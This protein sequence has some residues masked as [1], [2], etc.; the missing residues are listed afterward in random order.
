MSRRPGIAV[1]LA[2]GRGQRLRPA[3]DYTPKP[4]LPVDGCPT[5]DY[6]LTA[7]R[8]AGISTACIVTHHLAEQI[9]AYV[10]DGS[11]WSLRAVFCR[12]PE[13]NGTASALQT[14]AGAFPALFAGE[15]PFLLAA[16]DYA[17]A[18][19]ALDDLVTAH[20]QSEA[21]MTVSL[22]RLPSAE[23]IG[24]STVALN[25]D[26]RLLR[27]IEKPAPQDITT[28]LVASL[29]FV[30]PGET[31]AYLTGMERS[32]RG[33]YELQDVINR[34]LADGYTAD[35]LEQATPAEPELDAATA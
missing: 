18:P 12:Q 22:K 20:E 19:G 8:L 30:L 23:I 6:V 2:A 4:L 31:L 16:T 32:P 25:E 28:P 17:L 21:D 11:A 34:M 33:D 9:E 35:G 24:R 14:A 5:L 26:G 10:G 7:V 13:L 1:L 27:I 3:T 29:L 15:R